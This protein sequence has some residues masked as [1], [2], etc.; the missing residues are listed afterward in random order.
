MTLH[1]KGS[2]KQE[3]ASAQHSSPEHVA[4]F[5]AVHVSVNALAGVVRSAL[6]PMMTAS[7]TA[8]RRLDFFIVDSPVRVKNESSV[9]GF[10]R[11]SVR[12]ALA[13]VGWMQLGD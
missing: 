3:V 11:E 5:P 4:P 2:V 6:P 13:Q 12:R 1:V 8:F 10:G 9:K 7:A